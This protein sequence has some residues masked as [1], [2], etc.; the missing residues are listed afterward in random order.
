MVIALNGRNYAVRAGSS[1]NIVLKTNNERL[2]IVLSIR[3]KI[4]FPNIIFTEITEA[5]SES[6]YLGNDVT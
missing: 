2:V 4:V 1:E 3:I 6:N 5:H